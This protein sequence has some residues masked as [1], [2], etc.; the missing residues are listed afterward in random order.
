MKGILVSESVQVQYAT[1][2]NM[3]FFL[4]GLLLLLCVCISRSLAAISSLEP[5]Q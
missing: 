5:Q 3:A 2:T 4:L 1:A